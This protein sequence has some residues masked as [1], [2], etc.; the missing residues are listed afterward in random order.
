MQNR[1]GFTLVELAIVLVIIGII[2]AAV[3]KGQDLIVNANAKKV[4]A[5]TSSWR[6]L[7]YAYLDRNGRLPGDAGR[8]GIV[9]DNLIAANMPAAGYEQTFNSGAPINEIVTSMTYAPENPVIVGGLSFWVY[10]GNAA[11][12]VGTRN[13]IVICK[14]VACATNFNADEIEVIKSIDSAYDGAADAGTGQFRAATAITLAASTG[15]VGTPAR[16]SR[17]MTAA[18]FVNNTTVGAPTIWATTHRAAVWLFDRP[19]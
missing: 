4:A 3:I 2:L 18:T 11:A 1:R 5:A 17:T 15:T 10:M 12:A 7:T 16:D 6:N 19:F 8:N 13:A 9:G 14:D